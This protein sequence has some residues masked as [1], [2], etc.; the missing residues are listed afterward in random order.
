MIHA[1]ADIVDKRMIHILGFGT[2]SHAKNLLF[3]VIN[4]MLAVFFRCDPD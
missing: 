1:L 4:S 3:W 2:K